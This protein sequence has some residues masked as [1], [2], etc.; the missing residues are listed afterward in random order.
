MA[1]GAKGH[2]FESCRACKLSLANL[3]TAL[4]NLFKT[5]LKVLL[6]LV[7]LIN[8][9]AYSHQ[10]L[11]TGEVPALGEATRLSIKQQQ[12]L[13][14][15]WARANYKSLNNLEDLLLY[16]YT[17]EIIKRLKQGPQLAHYRINLLLLNKRNFNA[18]AIPG[19]IIGMNLG[20]FLLAENEGEVASVVAHELSHL[21]QEHFLRHLEYSKSANQA[22][23][24]AIFTGLALLISGNVPLG[25]LAIYGTIGYQT[26][27]YLRLSRQFENEADSQAIVLLRNGGFNLQDMAN[28]LSR[29]NAISSQ[30]RLAA[31]QSTHPLTYER[32]NN[33]LLRIGQQRYWSPII[34]SP[35]YSFVK[36]RALYLSGGDRSDEAG[37]YAQALALM[38]QKKPRQAQALLEK[39]HRQSPSSLLVFYSLLEAMIADGK[40]RQALKMIEEKQKYSTE[41]PMFSYFRALAYAKD[42][43][44]RSAIS[45]M[46]KVTNYY[47]EYPPLWLELSAYYGAIEDRYNLFRARSIYHLLVGEK[48]HLTATLKLAE[49]E[50][51]GDEAKLVALKN[52]D[53]ID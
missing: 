20:I 3:L 52:I 22:S 49:K 24:A 27:N 16:H 43:N 10:V 45:Y 11:A 34:Y 46:E 14:R 36:Q 42:K 21:S 33:A 18:F 30:D 12:Q 44:Y 6:C 13:G 8:G 28:I 37:A 2:R 23:L 47:P 29:L 17:D 51:Q 19:G 15:D 32:I 48:N 5:P 7:V 9:I 38:Q 25:T 31:Y 50:A 41:N 35:E 40:I 4:S 53:P 1:S 39:L 26:E